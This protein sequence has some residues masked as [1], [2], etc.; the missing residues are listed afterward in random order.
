[1]S[2]LPREAGPDEAKRAEA[3]RAGELEPRHAPRMV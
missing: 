2:N 3:A 1:M